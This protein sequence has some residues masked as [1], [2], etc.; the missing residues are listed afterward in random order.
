MDLADGPASE[1]DDRRQRLRPRR[2]GARH[3]PVAYPDEAGSVLESRAV[4]APALP[5]A[6]AQAASFRSRTVLVGL[7]VGIPLSALFLYLAFRK[8]DLAEVWRTLTGAH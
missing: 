4:P 7:L 8:A 3:D 1:G 5:R 2:C 6:E